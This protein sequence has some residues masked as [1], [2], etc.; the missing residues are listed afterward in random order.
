MR[1]LYLDLGMGAAGDMLAASLYE[2]LDESGR[3][4]FIEK[5]NGLG[6][7]GLEISAERS[8]KCGING[9][10]MRV[11]VDGMEE[12][13]HDHGHDHEHGHGHHEHS[14]PGSIAHIIDN[15]P[16]PENIRK[17]AN[18]IYGIIAGAESRAHGVNVDKIHFHEVG[19]LDAIA[20]VTGVCL[21]MDMIGADKVIASPVNVG[22]GKVKC[23]HGILP[24]PAPA[25]AYIL[26]G[27]PI[28]AG[29][30]E[31]EMCTPTGAALLKY[32]VDE[33]TNMPT[34]RVSAIG[35]GMGHKDF[36]AANCVRAMLGETECSGE[37][38]VTLSCNV[39]DMTPES[40]CYATGRFLDEGARDVYTVNIGMKKSRPAVMINVLCM[41]D[42]KDRFV[43][44]IFK[45]TST[46]GIRETG[47]PRYVLD[48]QIES[49]DTSMGTVRVKKCS[50]YGVCRSKPEY[51][52]IAVIAKEHNLSV[53]E[54]TE[55]IQREL[56]DKE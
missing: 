55:K 8:S 21:L 14:D 46:I 17:N 30:F 24:V 22:F 23:A 13:E 29:S 28:Y 16:L 40:I 51:E 4:A 9:T 47:G 2:L 26:E 52:D 54:A 33:F 34:M 53:S 25:T 37:S 38:I 27:I 39:D 41:P 49:V 15:L 50:G 45:Y 36:E 31:G 44:L 10:H 19:A 12:H 11:R 5:M 7:E 35:Y 3:S 18:E 43:R 6:I 32:F 56:Y 48:R 20:D 42:D 1:V